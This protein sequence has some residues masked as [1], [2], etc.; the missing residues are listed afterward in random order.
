[1][2]QARIDQ[3][4]IRLI[5]RLDAY[6]FTQAAAGVDTAVKA[7]LVGGSV[8]DLLLGSPI[9]DY[10]ICTSL[11]PDE[12]MAELTDL[13]VIPTGL[14]HGTVTVN[15]W[16]LY[17]E[18]TSLR[19]EDQYSDSRHPNAVRF[20]RDI[21]RD[22]ARRDFTINAI[23]WHPFSGLTDPFDGQ[24]DL[25]E[26][27]VRAVGAASERFEEDALRILRA[28]RFSAQLGFEIEAETAAAMRLSH[29]RLHRIARER[30]SVEFRKMLKTAAFPQIWLDWPEVWEIVFPQ[31]AKRLRLNVRNGAFDPALQYAAVY[32]KNRRRLIEIYNYEWSER[33]CLACLLRPLALESLMWQRSAIT[34]LRLPRQ[35]VDALITIGQAL[36]SPDFWQERIYKQGAA[37]EGLRRWGEY[38]D[39]ILLLAMACGPNDPWLPIPIDETLF[40]RMVEETASV[41]GEALPYSL[42]DL[43]INGRDL[44]E[45]G[46]PAGPQIAAVLNHLLDLVIST[47]VP[48]RNS[49]LRQA[50]IRYLQCQSV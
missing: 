31:L 8:R 39:E 43:A 30:M 12:L 29:D 49:D 38:W 5:E 17:C 44:L 19:E 45:L 27:L 21:N 48:N 24:K 7:W 35:L 4:A 25:Q 13:T 1:M 6:R 41:R 32:L 10:D 18:V 3:R 2:N 9:H 42:S 15:A 23:A 11:T 33:L 28:L 20:I 46:M 34:L 40:R 22:L 47:E 37:Q 50:A 16:G 26:G 14:P 36:R